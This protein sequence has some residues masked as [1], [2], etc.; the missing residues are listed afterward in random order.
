VYSFLLDRILV[1]SFPRATVHTL[2]PKKLF[3]KT[4]GFYQPCTNLKLIVGLFSGNVVCGF[5]LDIVLI[6]FA[7]DAFMDCLAR[8][9]V[10]LPT[11]LA[12]E[13]VD[14]VLVNAP[15]NAVWRLT[16]ETVCG[17]TLR[18]NEAQCQ[19]L[20]VNVSWHKLK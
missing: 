8:Q 19:M 9:A 5:D 14:I 3:C 6:L 2:K 1:S 13:H 18:L 7:R 4:V 15:P 17:P 16:V 10:L 11:D 20:L 12:F